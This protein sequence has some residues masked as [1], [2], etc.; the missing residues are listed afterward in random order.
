VDLTSTHLTPYPSTNTAI[1]G[2]FVL[3]PTMDPV[4][5]DRLGQYRL[6]RM[7]G[8]GGMGVVFEAEDEWLGRRVALKVLRSGLPDAQIAHD[9]FVREARAMA[10][11]EHA[12]VVTIY[13]VG[14]AGDRPFMAM[15]LLTGKT[16]ETRLEREGRLAV[17]D[18]VRIGREVAAGLAAAHDKGLVH[19][20]VKPANVWLEAGSG[21]VKLLDFGL[22]LARDSSN[23]TH[24][25]F[26]IGTPAFMSPEQA[27]GEPLDGR[28][29]L[30]SLGTLL[31]L[32]TTGERPFEGPTAMAVMRNLELHCP[33]RVN[34]RRL[35]V[36]AAFSNL[37]MELL[38]KE[39][40]DR[41]AS[42]GVVAARLA[43]PEMT[44]PSHL[45][46]APVASAS[47]LPV[48]VHS[49]DW[50]MESG[51]RPAP[52]SGFL[53]ALV[54]LALAIGAFGVYRYYT[55]TSHGRLEIETDAPGAEVQIVHDGQVRHT[56]G[57]G[58]QF[59]LPAGRYEL[60]LV[61]PRAGYRLTRGTVEVRRNGREVVR[62][63]RD[64]S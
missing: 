13:Q 40:K 42:A 12:N 37:I 3:G 63:I 14:E 6:L 59:D 36:P 54:L 57:A 48:A 58:G 46:I 15:Q 4:V 1:D 27:R 51:S 53:R 25:G 2:A 35:D 18:A 5:G 7:L 34:V 47:S 23:L 26:V 28:S 10:A 8:A 24:S 16:L 17:G 19:R 20:D 49:T 38:A 55:A 56:G 41:P 64:R 11:V 33:P 31:Y 62:V 43:R 9:R 52:S 44:R 22:A 60:V 50:W 45:P 21:R 32:M 61:R 29:D 39:P 30:F